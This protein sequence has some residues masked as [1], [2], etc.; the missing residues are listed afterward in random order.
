MKLAPSPKKLVA[1]KIR[2]KSPEETAAEELA[3]AEKK[4][5]EELVRA[6]KKRA[7]ELVRAE[8]ERLYRHEKLRAVHQELDQ[9]TPAA[10]RVE[11]A[12][13]V[14]MEQARR[15]AQEPD[16]KTGFTPR[17]KE[18]LEALAEE[19][20][21]DMGV[22]DFTAFFDASLPKERGLFDELIAELMVIAQQPPKPKPKV[23]IIKPEE[24]G[25]AYRL[26]K[27][28]AIHKAT[29]LVACEETLDP[30]LLSTDPVVLS[31]I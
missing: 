31:G 3:R 14:A 7:E 8:K 19:G 20:D 29:S 16:A 11:K 21:V 27:L 10:G 22:E 23:T 17:N 6:E 15:K 28:G 25:E 12:K 13:L 26:Q 4:R 30:S 1:P 5:A 2:V 9:H 24:Y 18:C